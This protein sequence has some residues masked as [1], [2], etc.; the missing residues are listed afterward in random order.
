VL[1]TFVKGGVH[2]AECKFSEDNAIVNLPLPKTVS[3]PIAQH[4]GAPSKVIVAKGDKVKVGDKI[5]ESTGFVSANIH[6]SVSGT[7]NKIDDVLDS[8]G[9]KRTCI[10]IDVEGDEWNEIIDRTTDLK[11]EISLT[12]KE[13]IAKIN[14]S[15]IVGLG[16]ATFPSHV[17]FLLTMINEQSHRVYYS[18]YL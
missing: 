1:K 14:A 8:T 12:E 5:A 3:I 2:P 4:I 10:I 16:G 15:G 13:I 7:V 18:L 9:Y 17:N 11:K 6:S